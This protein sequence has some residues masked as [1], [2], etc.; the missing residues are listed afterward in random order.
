M[1]FCSFAIAR[2][3]ATFAGAFFNKLASAFAKN[4]TRNA[5]KTDKC[6]VCCIDNGVDFQFGDVA[7]VG[8][9]KYRFSVV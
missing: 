3:A 4:A 2:C 5:S 9:V 1:S 6:F 7:A 8:I